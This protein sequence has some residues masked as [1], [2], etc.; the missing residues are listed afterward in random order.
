MV[1]VAVSRGGG[2]AGCGRMILSSNPRKVAN[3]IDLPELPDEA[4]LAERG[5]AKLKGFR[6]VATPYQEA[7]RNFL[8]FLQVAAI[9]IL[10]R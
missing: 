9:V 2:L 4:D 6:R 10:L 5:W 7:T 1:G 8:A 3:P